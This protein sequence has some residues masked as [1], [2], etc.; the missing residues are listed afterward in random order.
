MAFCNGG[1]VMSVCPCCGAE[2]EA[3]PASRVAEIVSPIMGEI[4]SRLMRKP[5]EFIPTREIAAFVYRNDPNGGPDNPSVNIA[6]AIQFNRRRLAALGWSIE[7]RLGFH[8]GYRV[9][10]SSVVRAR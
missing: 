5:G 6:N 8:G 1:A 3:Y 4:V 2:T 10:V 7:G 9:V